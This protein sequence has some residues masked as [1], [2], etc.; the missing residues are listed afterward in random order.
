MVGG[1]FTTGRGNEEESV[2]VF[3][4]DFDIGFIAGL[5]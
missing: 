1:D 5:D 2:V 3:T 4:G